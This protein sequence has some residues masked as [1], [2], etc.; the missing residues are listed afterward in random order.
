M[1]RKEFPSSVEKVDGVLDYAFRGGKLNAGHRKSLRDYLSGCSSSNDH[2]DPVWQRISAIRHI[3]GYIEAVHY[4]HGTSLE[5]DNETSF[6][7]KEEIEA[8]A[9]AAL[10]RV[11]T[12]FEEQGIGLKTRPTIMYQGGFSPLNQ[13]AIAAV[14]TELEFTQ[15]WL[16]RIGGDIVRNTYLANFGIALSD[17]AIDETMKNIS[18][19]LEKL[20]PHG[21]HGATHNADILLFEPAMHQKQQLEQ[22]IAHEVWH[23]IEKERGLLGSDKIHEASATFV[24]YRFAEKEIDW[25]DIYRDQPFMIFYNYGAKV[26]EEELVGNDRPLDAIL[27]PSVRQRLSEALDLRV[28]PLYYQAVANM[29]GREITS[30]I[31]KK[32][33]REHE[34]FEDFRQNPCE[35]N[36]LRA[37]ALRGYKTLSEELK[38]VE[39]ERLMKYYLRLLHDD[40]T[41]E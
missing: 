1:K 23:L 41:L 6:G 20:L 8:C 33:V 19:E 34:A 31:E 37:L 28:L 27:A 40:E 12:Y 26:I 4:G 5:I 22:I 36:I 17:R 30:P 16:V 21:I 10:D 39:L 32:L 25:S 3:L 7:S 11:L 29:A 13:H 15:K 38:G 2:K 18:V 35:E 24:E 14:D 9:E